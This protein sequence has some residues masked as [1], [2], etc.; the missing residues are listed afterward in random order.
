MKRLITL[1]ISFCLLAIFA[2]PAAAQQFEYA[3]N[4]ERSFMSADEF[5]QQLKNGEYKEFADAT[6]SVRQKISY[7]KVPDALMVFEKKTGRYFGQSKQKLSPFVHPKRQVYFF[8]SFV[9]TKNEEYWKYAVIDAET[10]RQLQSGSAYK[11]Y[12]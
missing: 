9:Q 11:S 3:A 10:K 12:K 7:K 1:V 4:Q 8:A 6:Y 5:Y 2:I